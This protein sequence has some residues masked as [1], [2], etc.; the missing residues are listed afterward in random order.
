MYLDGNS[1]NSSSV[2]MGRERERERER[3]KRCWPKT[4]L[5]LSPGSAVSRLCGHKQVRW[6]QFLCLLNGHDVTIIG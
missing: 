2:V 1:L 5:S 3:E 4:D 6:P